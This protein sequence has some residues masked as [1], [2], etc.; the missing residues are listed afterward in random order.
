MQN[1]FFKMI[2]WKDTLNGFKIVGDIEIAVHTQKNKSSNIFLIVPGVDGSIDGHQ[3]KY[4]KIAEDI[5]SYEDSTV[6]RMSNP[7]IHS[8]RLDKNLRAVLDYIA[9]NE[10]ALNINSDYKIYAMGHSLG[11]TNLAQISWEYPEFAKLLLINPT[12]KIDSNSTIQGLRKFKGEVTLLVG[13]RDQNFQGIEKIINTLLS[14]RKIESV[15][16]PNA[17][18]HF[19]GEAF[20]IFLQAAKKY[21]FEY[22]KK[23]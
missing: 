16:I 4:L 23:F 5:N 3:E 7:F 18:H 8:E 2:Q 19:A 12:P 17:N 11:A 14:E 20:P 21:L 6:I 13:Q 9:N 1:P 22:E 10:D 15:I